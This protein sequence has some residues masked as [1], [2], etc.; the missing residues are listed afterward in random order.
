ME[1]EK[2]E[3]AVGEIP[4]EVMEVDPDFVGLF[5][6]R[7]TSSDMFTEDKMFELGLPLP[8]MFKSEPEKTTVG[9]LTI[10][11]NRVLGFGSN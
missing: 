7:S 9:R 8:P 3:E 2:K 1:E 4:P 6:S 10:Y 5:L 11:K